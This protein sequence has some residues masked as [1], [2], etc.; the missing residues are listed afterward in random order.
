MAPGHR[1]TCGEYLERFRTERVWLEEIHRRQA[2]Q[3]HRNGDQLGLKVDASRLAPATHQ[4]LSQWLSHVGQQHSAQIL[5]IWVRAQLLGNGPKIFRPTL[6]QCLAMEQIAP[7]LPVADYDQPYPVMFVELPEAYS[8]R[9]SCPTANARIVGTHAPVGVLIGH[10]A[11]PVDALWVSIWLDSTNV[12]HQ[13]MLRR[14]ATI[15]AMIGEEYGEDGYASTAWATTEERV[16][17]AGVTRLAVNAMLLFMQFGCRRLGPVNES[18][19]RRLERYVQVAR[20]KRRGL[21]EAERNVQQ[22]PQ[23]YGFPQEVVLHEEAPRSAEASGGDAD[24]P[25]RPHWRRGH[26][27]MQPHGPHRSLRRR[28]FIKPV[29]VNGHLLPSNAGD[30][31]TVYRVRKAQPGETGTGGCSGP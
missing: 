9:R 15:E 10:F 4:W 17:L 13:L 25:R 19:Y 8:Q 27:K 11:T 5:E 6:D 1:M 20:K 26:W 2:V 22:A 7:Q 16:I 18:H 23:L 21:E 24:G 30:F 31:Q 3:P 14:E 28:L 29:L 12:T